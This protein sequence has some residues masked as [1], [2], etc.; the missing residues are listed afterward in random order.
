MQ[1]VG[2]VIATPCQH[3]SYDAILYPVLYGSP[4]DINESAGINP[5]SGEKGA[6]LAC[7]KITEGDIMVYFVSRC[8]IIDIDFCFIDPHIPDFITMEFKLQFNLDQGPV[9]KEIIFFNYR[10]IAETGFP[11][12]NIKYRS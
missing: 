2:I 5:V 1:P 10:D 3:I 11:F 4:V 12:Q 6:I 7:F 8:W 9:L